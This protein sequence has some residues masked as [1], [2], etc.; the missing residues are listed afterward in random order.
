MGEQVINAASKLV[1][2]LVLLAAVFGALIITVL[3]LRVRLGRATR[4]P[5]RDRKRSGPARI[6]ADD[7]ITVL[8]KTL[9]SGRVADVSSDS[10]PFS[11]CRLEAEDG[12]A[13][14]SMPS[15][16]QEA[17]YFPGHGEW[18]ESETFPESV[19]REQRV[20][21]R[22]AEPA[23]LSAGWKIAFYEGPDGRCLAIEELDGVC[24]LW[25]GKSIPAEG[26]QVLEEK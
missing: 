19:E 12:P 25:R 8:G 24:G 11:W 3:V 18:K 2:L 16:A 21:R 14:L 26:I 6:Q 22:T 7:V 13:L 17:F 5:G 1:P 9:V 23:E 4:N 20:Y 10:S 15:S